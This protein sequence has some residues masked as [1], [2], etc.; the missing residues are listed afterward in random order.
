MLKWQFKASALFR[1]TGI[2][3]FLN[4]FFRS[5]FSERHPENNLLVLT[6]PQ[7]FFLKQHR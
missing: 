4:S 6:H 3:L 1:N 7:P 2:R 5:G